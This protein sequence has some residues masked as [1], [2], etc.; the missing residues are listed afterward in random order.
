MLAIYHA[1]IDEGNAT[2]KTRAPAWEVFDALVSGSS[3]PAS[4]WAVGTAGGA[5]SS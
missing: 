1:G 5:T 2:F 4:G 3:A